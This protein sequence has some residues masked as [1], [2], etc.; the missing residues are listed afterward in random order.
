MSYV[1]LTDQRAIAYHLDRKLTIR[2]YLHIFFDLMY[3]ACA[4]SYIV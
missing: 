2:F 1:N 4:N 3:V